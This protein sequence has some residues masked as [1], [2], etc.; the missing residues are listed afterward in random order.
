MISFIL[1]FFRSKQVDE[2]LIEFLAEESDLANHESTI[3]RE[4]LNYIV[5]EGSTNLCMKMKAHEALR[6]GAKLYE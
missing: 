1:G 2:E 5:S 6:Q 4:A 3:Y